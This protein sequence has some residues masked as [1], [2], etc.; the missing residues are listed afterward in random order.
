M[1]RALRR[2][3][4]PLPWLGPGVVLGGLLPLAVLVY[5]FQTGYLGANPFQRATQQTGLLAIV[6][7]FLSLS[8]S[9]LRRLTGWTW[10]ARVRRALGLLAV[11][12][13]SAHLLI[14]ATD[15]GYSLQAA[16]TDVLK[17]PFITIGT[18]TLLLL[19][20]LALTSFKNSPRRLGF[21]R[22]QA[23][24]RLAYVCAGLASLHFYLSVK[25][26]TTQ[27]LAYAGVL[28]LLLLA[29]V[30]YTRLDRRR[31]EQKAARRAGGARALGPE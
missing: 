22:W 27:P 24:H 16:W 14:Y 15:K 4:A 17:R 6:L 30:V 3:A 13:A 2:P 10:P 28:A 31:A 29:R 12:Y 25:K 9:P 20:P 7:L 19:L 11:L 8:A 21:A 23:L 1:S 5:D 26:D 18:L